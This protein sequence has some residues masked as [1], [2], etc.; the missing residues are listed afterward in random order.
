MIYYLAHYFQP[1]Y[2]WLNLFHY[3]SVRASCAFL[4]SL[5]LFFLFGNSFIKASGRS[6]C[7]K[8]RDW[9]PDAHQ[10]KN[11]TPTMGGLFI[12]A[13]FFINALMWSKIS[14]GLVMMMVLGTLGYGTIGFFDDW[15]KIQRHKGLSARM[16]MMLQV[17]LG[18]AIGLCWYFIF[19][20]PTTA[21]CVPFFKKVQPVFGA[22]LPIWTMLVLVSTSNAVNLTDGLDGLV[23]GPLICN[24]A[25]FSLVAY[26]AGNK[27]FSSYLYIPFAASAELT[28]IGAILVGVMLGFLWYNAHPAQIFMGDV[29]SLSLGAALG[30]MALFSRQELLLFICGGIF[31]METLSVIIQ[32]FSFKYFGKR[33]FRMAPIHHHFELQGWQETKI[34]VRFWIISLILSVITLLSLKIR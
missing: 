3:V 34:T 21:L 18:L 1:S 17:S 4:S 19:P 7:S 15:G 22:F 28:V 30:M 11:N 12:L 26:L 2:S 32:V 33:L 23:S 29:G 25:T 27:T 10:K 31:V 5:F 13:I 24:F 9:V 8:V 6:F 20:S 16:K 14:D